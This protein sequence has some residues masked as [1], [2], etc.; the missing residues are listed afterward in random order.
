MARMFETNDRVIMVED[1]KIRHGVID[2]VFESVPKMVVVK[3]DDGEIEKVNIQH[4]AIE[5]VEKKEEPKVE[6]PKVEEKKE[7]TDRVITISESEFT[8]KMA[9]MTVENFIMKKDAPPEALVACT[10]LVAMVHEKLFD[11]SDSNA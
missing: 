7:R 2:H 8:Q 5:P 1:G 9:E 4:L 6:E 10:L 3:F 11:E